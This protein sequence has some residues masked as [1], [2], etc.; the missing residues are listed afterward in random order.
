MSDPTAGIRSS[1]AQASGTQKGV[2]STFA[3]GK[4]VQSK[5]AKFNKSVAVHL[6]L[7][8]LVGIVLG[9]TAFLPF[10]SSE[11][12][13]LKITFASLAVLSML[14]G[15]W[16]SSRAKRK[17]DWFADTGFWQ[18]FLLTFGVSVF[19]FIGIFLFFMLTDYFIA[20]VEHS[21]PVA[22]IMSSVSIAALIPLCVDQS[23][24]K[25][26]EIAPKSYDYWIFP[27]HYVEKQ[28]TWNRDRIIYVNL[29]FKR[30][31]T[32]SHVTTAKVRFP[33]EAIFSEVI[34]LFIRD[35]NQNGSPDNPI[36]GLTKKEG[37]E[38]WLFWTK[39]KGL[40]S[41]FKKWR[42]IDVDKTVEENGILDKDDIFFERI[43][44]SEL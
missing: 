8:L 1:R 10:Y 19:M 11:V 20:I 13:L 33:K 7:F 26:I 42:L 5:A 4:A 35:Y 32:E 40:K 38:G 39:N 12:S 22:L 37:T 30:K 17:I 36:T 14:I 27:E 24:E 21:I 43:Q 29:H 6:M 15:I 18:K 9:L 41:N 28:P 23:F 25:A 2:K 31:Q 3:R 16:H 34:Y 44:N